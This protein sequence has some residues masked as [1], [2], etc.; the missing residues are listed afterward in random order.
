M[1]RAWNTRIDE[2]LKA[3]QKLVWGVLVC[4]LIARYAVS[5]RGF[6]FDFESYLIV[7][8]LVRRGE[9]VYANTARYNYGPVWFNL[10]HVAHLIGAGEPRLFRIC[11]I[12][13]LSLVD[14]G[15][16]AIFYRRLGGFVATLF[17]L[18]PISIIITGYHNQFD[19]LAL[20]IGMLGIRQFGD[21]FDLALTGRKVSGL[22]LLGLSLITKQLLF[23]FPIWLAVKQRGLCNKVIVVF[24]PYTLFAVSFLPYWSEGSQGIV[25]NVLRYGSMNNELFY[26]L[27]VPYSLRLLLPSKV[28]WGGLLLF[29][30][31]YFRR[32]NG[33]DSLLFYTCILVATSPSIANQY[34][35]IAVP[36]VVANLNLFTVAYIAI[37]TLY[38]VVHKSGLHVYALQPFAGID[39]NVY[40]AG[41]I[42]LL[43]AG[44]IWRLWAEHLL[45]FAQQAWSE[46][47]HQL[48]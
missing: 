48:G 40:R 46:F 2:G 14:V 9:N 29:F 11:V 23:L 16:F 10:L 17:F 24:M 18:N 42:S 7:A 36:F 22:L 4:G 31:F 26:Q 39:R 38:L 32:W 35:A 12:T 8:D 33:F 27:F 41:L 30:A 25:H 37:G 43:A 15:I 6:N 47:K 13:I 5:L 44:F 45:A 1:Q 20:L 28:V 21:D 19:N 3:N 34:V